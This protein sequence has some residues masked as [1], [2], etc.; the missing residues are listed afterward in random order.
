MYM[1]V[2][3]VDITA[4]IIMA[5]FKP[6]AKPRP[7]KISQFLGLNT[8]V[9]ETEIRIGEAVYMRNYK[10][11][12]NYKP[13][14][15]DGHN[16]FINYGNVLPVY[17]G[18]VGVLASKNILVTC[19]NG[20]VYEYNYA[21]LINTEI[22][23]MTNLPT[24]I[25]YFNNKIYLQNGVDFKYYDG[26]TFG[27]VTDIAYEP[28]IAIEAPPTG[29]G[30]LFEEI[31]L[32]TGA[33]WQWFK[34]NGTATAYTLAESAIDANLVIC[35]INGVTK[36]E[37]VD[38]T[39]N[40]TTGVVTFSVAPV[41]EAIV[42]LKWFKVTAGNADLVKKHRFAIKA[43]SE[44]DT[45]LFIWG[46]TSEPNIY[47]VSGTD[48]PNYFPAN[49]FYKVSDNEYP[50][51]DLQPMYN[52]IV[53]FKQNRTHFTYA[54]PNPLYATN[55]GL[56][57]FIYPVSDLNESIGNMTYN[58]VQLV[59]NSPVSLHADSLWLWNNTTVED[60]RNADIIS[61]RVKELLQE[62]DLATAITYDY[63]K[64]KELWINIGQLVYVWNYGNDTWYVHDNIEANWF[65]EIDGVL[66]YGAHGTIEKFDGYN[67]NGVAVYAKMELGFTDFGVNSLTKNTRKIWITIQPQTRTSMKVNFETD[68]DF[69][70]AD[71][72]QEVEYLFLNFNDVDFNYFPFTA[73]PNPQ[74]ERLRIRAKKYQYIRF[75]FENNRLNQGLTILNFEV[76]ADT[77]GEVK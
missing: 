43:G 15:R 2:D 69:L 59:K 25:T 65:L 10:I 17:G 53:I 4:V 24:N 28:V 56:N 38:F 75:I 70:S 50:I 23:T 74:G 67:D 22:G 57:Q 39:V 33:K 47:R 42:K 60:E 73:N 20:K 11:T 55:T 40:R 51:T 46:N 14:K 45:N 7:I 30:T 63:Q 19:N 44:N 54:Q 29:G 68:E 48:K 27:N 61:D 76:Q 5:N 62:E 66:H 35:T 18:W 9:G 72:E 12:K 8:S 77:A 16:T 36:V 26:T 13:Q 1:A 49:S 31:N 52:R 37:T 71:N 41:N 64:E 58:A 3:M 32:M 6:S 34:A 21:T